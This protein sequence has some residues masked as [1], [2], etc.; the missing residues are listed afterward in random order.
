M[1]DLKRLKSFSWVISLLMVI[2]CLIIMKTQFKQSIVTSHQDVMTE[3]KH[4]TSTKYSIDTGGADKWL[5]KT[6]STGEV[7]W[8]QIN[9]NSDNSIIINTIMIK[10][11]I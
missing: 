8:D 1:S 6:T 5:I 10:D 9:L 2:I 3:T 7:E 11:I 4:V